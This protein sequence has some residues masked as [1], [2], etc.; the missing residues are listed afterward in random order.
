MPSFANVVVFVLQRDGRIGVDLEEVESSEVEEDL[1]TSFTLKLWV[2]PKV[3]YANSLHS[4]D[5]SRHIW[6]RTVR[7]RT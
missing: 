2:L 6:L 5:N 3:W 4:V 1:H 7:P